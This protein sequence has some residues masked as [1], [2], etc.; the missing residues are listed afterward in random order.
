[1]SARRTGARIVFSVAVL[2]SVFYLFDAHAVVVTLAATDVASML[3]AV[4]LSL[5]AQLFSAMRLRRLLLIQEIALPLGRVYL[6]GLSAVFYGLLIPGGT[7]AAFAVRFARLARHA[8]LETIAAA[9]VVDRVVATVFLVAIGVVAAAFDRADPFWVSAVAVAAACGA[10]AVLARR[11][12]PRLESVAGPAPS[13]RLAK[14]V[15]RVSEAF[16]RYSTATPRQILSLVWTSLLAHV[17]GCLAYCA[18]AKGMG[19]DLALLTACWVRSGVILATMIPVSLA[20]IGLRELAAIGLL[21][22][23]G[24]G[25]A[26]A[27]GY[28]LLIFLVTAVIVGVIG[29]LS[30][31]GQLVRR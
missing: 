3:L 5:S 8:R 1:M 11:R 29:G 7:V 2:V 20:G 26:D 6:I 23:L 17:C 10:A 16:L 24:F 27:I 4:A 21:V 15:R 25:E 31:L 28:S 9:L 19:L 13:G 18:I 14:A 22:P 12:L 30:E